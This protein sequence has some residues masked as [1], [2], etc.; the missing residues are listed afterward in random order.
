MTVSGIAT[1]AAHVCLT[2]TTAWLGIGTSS[3]QKQV[4]VYNSGTNVSI[5]SSCASGDNVLEMQSA[6]NGRFLLKV[7]ST[8]V[9][10]LFAN[11]ANSTI[12]GLNINLSST[13]TGLAFDTAGNATFIGSIS[14]TSGNI[15]AT[16]SVS[17]GS[18]VLNSLSV[19][20]VI[21]Q[22]EPI[23]T[24]QCLTPWEGL[25]LEWTSQQGQQHQQHHC[26][27]LGTAA[28][29]KELASLVQEKMDAHK[30][31]TYIMV[32]TLTGILGLVAQVAVQG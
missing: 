30:H 24:E 20:G 7:G 23:P 2:G 21:L 6:T 27:L 22:Q 4:E 8:G 12:Y 29:L 25:G 28:P 5:K 9:I 13:K 18:G 31:H 26:M 19:N 16:G 10:N 15:V 11:N 1:H 17:A 14:T 32:I 3:P